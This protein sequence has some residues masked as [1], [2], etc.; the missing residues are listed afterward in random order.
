ML[1]GS[2]NEWV[3]RA[4]S[5][6]LPVFA[7]AF[8]LWGALEGGRGL[9]AN[10]VDWLLRAINSLPWHSRIAAGIDLDGSVLSM[11][12][13]QGFQRYYTDDPKDGR[14]ARTWMMFH[15]LVR[16]GGLDVPDP[17]GELRKLLGVSAEDLWVVGMMFWTY[18]FVTTALDG[19][20]WAFDP[21]KF[22]LEGQHQAEMADLVS[23]VLR[24]VALTPKQ[25]RER[26]DAPDSKYRDTSGRVGYW[27]SEFNILRDFPL[28]SL[29][30]GLYAA[31][32]PA[33]GLT[34]AI[35]GFYFDLL[36]EFGRQKE[37]S[38]AP[39]N[40]L[41]NEMNRTLGTLFE[42]YVGRQLGLLPAPGMQLRGEFAYRHKKND[43]KSTDWILSRPG[44]LPVLFECKA[45]EPAQAL[46][47]TGIM[48]QLRTEV[49]LAL[50]KACGQMAKFIQAI[51]QKAQGL[52]Q[53]HGQKEFICAVVLWA[54]LPFH[55][56][57][58]IRRVIEETIVAKTPAWAT[59]RNRIHFVPMAVRELE[60]A[61]ATEL[62]FGVPIEDQLFEYARYREKAKRLEGPT[63]DLP[64]YPRHLEDFLQER[65]NGGRRIVNPLCAAAWEEFGAF[66]QQRI[67]GEDIEV[68]DRELFEMT[69]K[70][71]Y[72]LWEKRGKP[73]WDDL[74]D[75]FEAEDQIAN[76][77]T[78][79]GGDPPL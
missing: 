41:D 2:L 57:R 77:P 13:R 23:R 1:R 27:L 38:G 70:R 37:A 12:I 49:Q 66:C 31:P 18:H 61:V 7:K 60:T 78:L 48:D 43:K 58:D 30:Q 47:R 52:E 20:K 45:R 9:T 76:D 10:D 25:F 50:G 19:R 4:N 33:F 71:A 54:P 26:Y 73:L 29:G 56:I 65:F 17:S 67:F 72:E 24:A 22:V 53:Y 11:L 32:F 34:R 14:I 64:D 21:Q 6:N 36:N 39:G 28:V 75:W 79:V 74:R 35:D 62:Q 69:Q 42:R 3:D 55:Q 51:D 5:F 44:R 46:Q 40:S 68:A 63:S 59:L 8:V 15:E 16:D